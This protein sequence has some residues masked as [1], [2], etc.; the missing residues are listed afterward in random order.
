METK[1]R[2]EVISDLEG[3]KREL[4]RERDNLNNELL[5]RQKNLKLMERRKADWLLQANREIEDIKDDIEQFEKTMKDKR[6]TIN[7]LI[8]SVEDSLER[9]TKLNKEKK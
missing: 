4:I 5:G 8:K 9:F 7:E 6:D 2:Y 3:K 1:S